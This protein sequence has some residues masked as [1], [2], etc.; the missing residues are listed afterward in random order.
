MDIFFLGAFLMIL[1]LER[2]RRAQKLDKSSETPSQPIFLN[3]RS[4][5][6]IPIEHFPPLVSHAATSDSSDK[7]ATFVHCRGSALLQHCRS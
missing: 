4:L 7:A 6:E 2:D 3:S 5:L 1:I